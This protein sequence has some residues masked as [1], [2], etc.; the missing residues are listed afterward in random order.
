MI[1]SLEKGGMIDIERRKRESMKGQPRY[2]RASGL[3]RERFGVFVKRLSKRVRQTPETIVSRGYVGNCR[4]R[5]IR[6]RVAVSHCR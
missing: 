5:G 2:E 3:I 6:T 1:S 4:N